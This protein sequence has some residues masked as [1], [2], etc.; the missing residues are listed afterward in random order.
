M[1]KLQCHTSQDCNQIWR[2]HT[3]PAEWRNVIIIPLPKTAICQNAAIGVLT[4]LSVPRKIIV[5][6]VLDR[7]KKAVDNTTGTG[8]F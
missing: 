7:I 3:V 6:V 5:S 1:E 8:R 4:L 2:S